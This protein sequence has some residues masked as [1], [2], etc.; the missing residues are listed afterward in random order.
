MDQ[1]TRSTGVHDL[2]DLGLQPNY[3]YTKSHDWEQPSDPR[4]NEEIELENR[5]QHTLNRANQITDRS[6]PKTAGRY[7]DDCQNFSQCDT[8]LRNIEQILRRK[9][10]AL[11]TA[12]PSPKKQTRQS[13]DLSGIFEEIGNQLT[14]TIDYFDQQLKSRRTGSENSAELS[15]NRDQCSNR[16][17]HPTTE[18]TLNLSREVSRE[19]GGFSPNPVFKA[20]DKLELKREQERQLNEV[21]PS[22]S[23]GFDF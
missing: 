1:P 21:K 10:S 23:Y 5:A 14:N 12:E 17:T 22:R 16:G 4:T 13:A 18:P 9:E 15:P 3:R 2:S 8:A 11:G 7:R 20:L 6:Q 19:F